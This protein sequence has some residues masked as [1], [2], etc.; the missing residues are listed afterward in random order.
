MMKN[1]WIINAA[2]VIAVIIGVIRIPT[3]FFYSPTLVRIADTFAITP[4]PIPYNHP[5]VTDPEDLDRGLSFSCEKS[6]YPDAR[7]KW[8]HYVRGNLAGPH[9][10][11]ISYVSYFDLAYA[12]RNEEQ[13]QKFEMITR[14]YFCNNGPL[15]LA[16]ACPPMVDAVLISFNDSQIAATLRESRVACVR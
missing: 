14:V 12:E 16:A 2:G 10:R 9:R 11:T 7:V 6:G 8:N 4:F 15:A 1:S 13:Q 3:L 5:M